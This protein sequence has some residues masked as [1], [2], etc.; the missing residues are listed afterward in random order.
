MKVFSAII[1]GYGFM[2]QP[3]FESLYA[4]DRIKIKGLI[5]PDKKS[6]YYFS[7]IKNNQNI[8]TLYTSNL[9]E[10]FKFIKKLNVDVV[11]IST[12]NKILNKEFLKLSKFINI[13]HGKLPKQK[14][15]ASINWAIINGRNQVYITIH[16]VS[17]KLDAGPIIYQKKIIIK[18]NDDYKNI[19]NK[20]NIF[21]KNDLS[22]IILK[23]LEKKI[24]SKKNDKKQETWNC[25]RNPE[26]GMINFF[27]TRKKVINLIRGIK[28]KKFG[29]F[30]FLKE[31][32]IVILDAKIKSKRKYEGV[33]PGRIT[34]IY[35]NGN[36]DV[37]CCDGEIRVTKIF[38]KNKI[39]SPSKI[40]NSTKFTL[41]ND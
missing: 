41:L 40:I 8:E 38:Y 34:K 28:D 4:N 18:K 17:A 10:I 25:G 13:H 1:F 12:F 27:E 36:I 15:R 9:K 5:L 20:V 39:L 3:S 35:N 26:D 30:C 23:Y 22:K 29:A 11:I 33:I 7:S 37:L 2:A 16:Q 31:K 14:G 21:L 6:K 19:K 24:I 32:K